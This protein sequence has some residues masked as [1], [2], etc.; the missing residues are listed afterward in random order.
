MVAFGGSWTWVPLAIEALG[1]NTSE[2]YEVILVDNGGAE[3]ASVP[4]DARVELVRNEENVGFG[5]ASNKG[6][7]LARA[8][9]VCL[10]NP[11]ALVRP[12]W[13]PPLLE[14]LDEADVG[15]AVPAK[16]NAD[17]TMQQAGA[18]VTGDANAYIFGYGDDPNAP[19]YRFP[20]EV[21]YGSAACMCTTKSCFKSL[22]GFDPSYRKA[23][24]EDADL[25]FRMRDRGLRLVYEPRA[26]VTH[27][28]SVSAPPQDLA[29]LISEN[30]RV[31]EARW[32]ASIRQRPTLEQLRDS[33]RMQ[34]AARDVHAH[35]R[36]LIP[37]A[38][39][40]L[41]GLAIDIAL[42][43]PRARVTLLSDEVGQADENRLL[44]S[45]VE[46]AYADGAEG[47]LTERS[48]HYS[49]VIISQDARWFH[50]RAVLQKA[51]P[52]ARLIDADHL[53]TAAP[54]ES[55]IA[56]TARIGISS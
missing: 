44:E 12:A 54:H 24:F 4:D 19:E 13:L 51:Q 25:C 50:L 6:V 21:D 56:L 37:D 45:G 31:F 55:L 18:F 8:D 32:G 38:E 14:R 40:S 30:R 22:G 17:G 29:D 9:V 49:H 43:H 52:R 34:L 1:R 35:N 16:L 28:R 36:V 53:L 2:P 42:A 10:L 26:R 15:A 3:A 5:P 41:R 47:W 33:T 20:R 27:V 11:D 46:V 23:Y 39:E 48:G 7:E